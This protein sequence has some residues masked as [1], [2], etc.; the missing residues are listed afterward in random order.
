MVLEGSGGPI[1]E[2]HVELFLRLSLCLDDLLEGDGLVFVEGDAFCDI[3]CSIYPFVTIA[4]LGIFFQ[5][6]SL[7]HL[8]LYT[9]DAAEKDGGKHPE[10]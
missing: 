9:Y 5:I 8:C 3:G 10:F 1:V 7:H 6:G 2:S 4:L